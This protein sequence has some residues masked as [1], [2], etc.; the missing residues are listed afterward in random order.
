MPTATKSR[1]RGSLD[2]PRNCVCFNLR[3]AARAVTQVY[4][5]ILR[6]TGLRATQHSL[7]RVLQ[8]AGT[9]SVTKLAEVAVMDRTTLAR[10]LD[11]LERE[12]LVRVQSGADAR[13]REVALTD[14]AHK[15][16]AAALPYWEKAQAQ[17]TNNL[18]SGRSDRLLSDLSAAV[19][20]AHPES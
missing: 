3:K 9:V 8:A 12:G 14:V 11:L 19:S 5:E 2:D 13:V 16:L 4:D 17:V 7:L 10:N 18:G 1:Q 15:R 6:P 20:A